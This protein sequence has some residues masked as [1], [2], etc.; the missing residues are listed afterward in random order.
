MRSGIARG[1]FGDGLELGDDAAKTVLVSVDFIVETGCLGKGG[2]SGPEGCIEMGGDLE[3]QVLG[4]WTSG[5]VLSGPGAIS[6]SQIV[7]LSG[8]SLIGIVK[9]TDEGQGADDVSW[10]VLGVI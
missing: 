7:Y 8:G 2:I 3:A 5:R 1:G 9:T 4:I 6:Q 10:E